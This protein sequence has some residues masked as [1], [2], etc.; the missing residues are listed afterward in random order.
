MLSG[1]RWRSWTTQK[2]LLP[3]QRAFLERAM[4][5]YQEF[6]AP[7]GH[8]TSEGRAGGGRP[9]PGRPHPAALGRCGGGSRVPGGRGAAEKLAADFPAVPDYRWGLASSHISLGQMLAGQ[10]ERAE[11]E[12]EYRAGVAL[13]ETLAA[14]FPAVPQYRSNLAVQ[15]Q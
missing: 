1:S 6:A 3:A 10:G 7:G 4:A 11:A 8:A 13:A 14:D 15:P 12:A 9:V 5:Y 2:E